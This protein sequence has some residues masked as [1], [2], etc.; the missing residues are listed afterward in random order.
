MEMIKKPKPEM[1]KEE[2]FDYLWEL[3]T[4]VEFNLNDLDRRLSEVEKDGSK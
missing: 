1:S 2:L 4:A 3:A